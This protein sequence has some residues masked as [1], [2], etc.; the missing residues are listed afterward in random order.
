MFPF[1]VVSKL[2]VQSF[3]NELDTCCQRHRL[4]A[5]SLSNSS[6]A[7]AG[8]CCGSSICVSATT[9]LVKSWLLRL[10]G[11]IPASSFLVVLKK[12]SDKKSSHSNPL[13]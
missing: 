9:S 12:F 8:N 6:G 3:T 4:V 2:A 13:Q 7:L 5:G 11:R 1:L 10:V